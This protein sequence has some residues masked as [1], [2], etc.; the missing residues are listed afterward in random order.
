[1]S[2]SIASFKRL[3]NNVKD[4]LH[5]ISLLD[6]QHEWNHVEGEYPALKQ[7]LMDVVGIAHDLDTTEITQLFENDVDAVFHDAK[8]IVLQEL[9][10]APLT[11]GGSCS[12]RSSSGV[13]NSLV[14]REPVGLPEFVG[15]EKEYFAPLFPCLERT[16]GSAD[17]GLR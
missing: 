6:K 2:V 4:N 15:D 7:Q 14:R 1:M 12:S 11:S 16:A 17:S 8:G 3:T 13:I 10:D 5:D 9:K